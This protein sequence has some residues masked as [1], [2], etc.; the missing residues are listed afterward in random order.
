MKTKDAPKHSSGS[1][2]TDVKMKNSQPLTTTTINAGDGIT[3]NL[4]PN[5]KTNIGVI[6]RN[7]TRIV[8]QDPSK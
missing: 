5:A 4:D 6:G 3:L 1:V 2:D 7:V 8:V